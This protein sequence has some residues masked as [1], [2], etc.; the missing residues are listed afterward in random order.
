MLDSDRKF[1]IFAH[2]QEVLDAIEEA[3]QSKVRKQKLSVKSDTRWQKYVKKFVKTFM[4]EAKIGRL[5]S[6]ISEIKDEMT[7]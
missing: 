1:L 4:A 7:K 6:K 2:H 3:V 5:F